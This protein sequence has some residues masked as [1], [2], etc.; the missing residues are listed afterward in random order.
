MAE[1]QDSIEKIVATN[2]DRMDALLSAVLAVSSDLDLDTTL[3]HIVQAAMELA[4][5]RYGALGVLGADGM[6][7]QFVNEGVDDATR[8]LIGPL[9]TGRGVLGVV[10]ESTK[11][12][13]LED[14]SQHPSSI[15][16]PPNHPPMTTFLGVPILARGA[17]FGRL[18]LT[19]KA[20]G[21]QFTA[22]DEAV[23]QAL[24]GAAGIA[25]DNARL[26]DEG[27]RRQLWLEATSEITAELLAGSDTT[28]DL[29]LIANKAQQ[30]TAADYTLIALADDPDVPLSEIEE[31]TVAVCVGT[32]AETLTGQTIPISGSTTG[33][34]FTD[35]IPRNVTKLAF[36]LTEEAGPALALPLGAGE[37]LS[38]V[39]VTVRAPGSP[40]FDEHQLQVVASF[41]DQAALALRRAE[42]ESARR[43]L[44]VLAD[45][46]RIA[47]DLHDQVIQRLFAI[48]LAMQGTQRRAKTPVLADRLTD[49]IEQLQQVILD[50]RTAIFDL[51]AEPEHAPRLRAKLHSAINELTAEIPMRTTVRMAGPLDVV[52]A[53]LAEH[54]VAVVRE[55]VSNAVRHSGAR[56]LTVTISVDDNVVIDIADDGVGVAATV[57]RSGLENMAERAAECGGACTVERRRGGGTHVV[58]SAPL[59]EV[60]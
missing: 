37:V 33:A 42:G 28:A 15:G 48:G 30:L 56:T 8:K 7:I 43:E 40:P 60:R 11:P 17:V 54:T 23:V 58:W 29:H 38:G 13:V 55:A 19:E 41:A 25:I 21:G 32:H 20:T 49:H 52:P 4:G 47:R 9:P 26:F 45:R 59:P 57:D 24:A 22:D 27:R 34:V 6:L 2:R 16:F 53:V 1:V 50:I 51:H 39:L 46:D 31:L 35:H 5:A 10:I 44:E 3:R 12:L 36:G 18:Y 14:L